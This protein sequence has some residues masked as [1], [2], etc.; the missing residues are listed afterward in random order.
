MEFEEIKQEDG[1]LEV[2]S[3]E[4]RLTCIVCGNRRFHQRVSLLNTRSGEFLGVAWADA[5]ATN[6]ICTQCGYI[7]WFLT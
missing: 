6:F 2:V 4:K 5:Q 7:F 1:S 3:G